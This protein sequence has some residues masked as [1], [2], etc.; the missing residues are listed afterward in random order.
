MGNKTPRKPP[1][2][3]ASLPM[4]LSEHKK[5]TETPDQ[6]GQGRN[7]TNGKPNGPDK[8]SAGEGHKFG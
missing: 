1:S 2:E 8:S 4:G 5:I 6:L 3:G 7:E